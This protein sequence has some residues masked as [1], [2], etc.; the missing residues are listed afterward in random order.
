MSLEFQFYY[1]KGFPGSSVVKNLPGLR[2]ASWKGNGNPLQ[3]SC[4]ENSMDRG[5]GQGTAHGIA[6]DGQHLVTKPPSLF[7]FPFILF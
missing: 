6:R 3:F 1:F 5:T 2:R 7:L 4:L